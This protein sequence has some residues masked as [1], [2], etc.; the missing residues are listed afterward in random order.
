MA[1]SKQAIKRARQNTEKYKL[2]HAQRSVVRTAVKTVRAN[3][4]S[5][6]K[7]KAI[8]SLQKANKVLDSAASKKVI[9]KNAAARTKSRLSKAVKQ[10]N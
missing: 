10:L 3:I 5:Q 2:R 4:E 9:H 7:E 1:N 6:N 8:E